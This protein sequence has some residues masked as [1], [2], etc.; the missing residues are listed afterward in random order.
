M[1]VEV[2]GGIASGKTTLVS[3]LETLD[4]AVGRERFASNPFF[5]KFYADPTGYA[6]ETELVYLLQHL[7]Q[8]KEVTSLNRRVAFD[9][10]LALDLAYARVTLGAR[11]QWTFEHLLDRAIEK[12]GPPDLVVRLRCSAEGELLR[13]QERGRLAEQRL[14]VT[15]L[16]SLD[17]ELDLALRSRWFTAVPVLSI[18]SQ[19]L[20]FRPDGPDREHVLQEITVASEATR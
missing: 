14:G 4:F 12:V 15:F 16:R 8:I 5:E 20:D 19:A 6:F 7:S 18:D 9:F 3:A 13:I 2:C 11:D 10:S 1:R 17:S